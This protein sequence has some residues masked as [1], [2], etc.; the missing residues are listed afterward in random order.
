V[1]GG[2]SAFKNAWNNSPGSPAR[3]FPLRQR[4][5]RA[6]R[7]QSELGQ[8]Q[9]VVD[10]GLDPV[11]GQW[12]CP[13]QQYWGMGPHQKITPGYC[14]KL[15]FTATAT[16]SYEEAALVAGRW[17]QQPVSAATIHKL[18]QRLGAR[19]QQQTQERLEALP[20]QEQPQRSSSELAHC[21]GGWVDGAPTGTWMGLQENAAKPRRMA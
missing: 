6:L 19:A 1:N 21:D 16:G 13:L 5:R 20:P 15:C 4:K 10:Y 11:N 2:G 8:I 7:L 17:L 9:V 3:F 18:V 14:D 12:G